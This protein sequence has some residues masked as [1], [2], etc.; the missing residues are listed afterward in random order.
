MIATDIDEVLA[1]C[2]AQLNRFHNDRYGTSCTLEGTSSYHLNEVWGCTAEE[3]KERIKEFYASQYFR[4]ISPIEESK[5][6]M[7]YL[8][9]QYPITAITARSVDVKDITQT[10]MA[11]HYPDIQETYFAQEWAIEGNGNPKGRICRHIG[12][13]VMIEDAPEFILDCAREGIPV[14]MMDRPWNQH[15]EETE[16]ITRI[17]GLSE[18]IGSL[19]ELYSE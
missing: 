2:V 9:S 7:A 11:T 6:V 8:G 18:M 4:D 16:Y 3:A 1:H 17:T 19:A 14:F 12:A 5:L 10:F 15:I 13:T